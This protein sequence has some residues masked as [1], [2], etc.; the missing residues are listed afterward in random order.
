MMKLASLDSWLKLQLQMK[1]PDEEF[2]PEERTGVLR[3]LFT[4]CRRSALRFA[5]EIKE[6][7]PY[8]P[9]V[10]LSTED[11]FSTKWVQRAEIID[12]I[13][14]TSGLE[15]ETSEYALD[16]MEKFIE[17]RLSDSNWTLEI[18]H[19]GAITALP[20]TYRC[21]EIAFSSTMQL[22]PSKRVR[23]KRATG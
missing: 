6:Q 2:L 20:P 8:D 11:R 5:W 9:I 3:A 21:Y 7:H 18:E 13:T 10:K 4:S 19:L 15:E 23:V 17:K 22:A 14:F 16:V 1:Y 12:L